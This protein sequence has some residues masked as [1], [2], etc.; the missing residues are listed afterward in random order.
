MNRENRIKNKIITDEIRP[1]NMGN[2]KT[3]LKSRRNRLEH[4]YS[5]NSCDNKNVEINT[6]Y[7]TNIF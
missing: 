3:A 6:I 1:I 4:E 5:Y 7:I 2:N